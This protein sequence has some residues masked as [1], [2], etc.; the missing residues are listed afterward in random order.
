[1]TVAG[2]SLSLLLSAARKRFGLRPTFSRVACIP[3]KE[4]PSQVI[5]QSLV[6]NDRRLKTTDNSSIE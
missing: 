3:A 5:G 1:M 6:L 2:P 4:A